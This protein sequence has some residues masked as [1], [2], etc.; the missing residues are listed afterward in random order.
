LISV[1]IESPSAVRDAYVIDDM[2]NTGNICEFYGAGELEYHTYKNI[3]SD[4]LGPMTSFPNG[5]LIAT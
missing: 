1:L 3:H 2:E 5:V 4:N